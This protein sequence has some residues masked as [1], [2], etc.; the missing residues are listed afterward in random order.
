MQKRLVLF[1]K[2]TWIYWRKKSFLVTKVPQK[3]FAYIAETRHKESLVKKYQIINLRRSAYMVFNSCRRSILTPTIKYMCHTLMLLWLTI[4]RN[5]LES[6]W[7]CIFYKRDHM[8]NGNPRPRPG[9]SP[10][11][12]LQTDGDGDFCRDKN[13]EKKYECQWRTNTVRLLLLCQ[14]R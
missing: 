8:E 3:H 6:G 7:I 10:N 11:Q 5:Q 14:Q 12:I 2:K 13:K 9:E 4:T 1:H